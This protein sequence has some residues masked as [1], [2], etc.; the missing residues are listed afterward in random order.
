MILSDLSAYV[1]SYTP[2]DYVYKEITVPKV[3]DCRQYVLTWRL[4]LLRVS[5][6]TESRQFVKLSLCEDGMPGWLPTRM[7][8][9]AYYHS[10]ELL[11]WLGVSMLSSFSPFCQLLS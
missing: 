5:M 2:K 1:V 6:P 11:F 10:R 3:C 9:K 4:I 7:R 8:E